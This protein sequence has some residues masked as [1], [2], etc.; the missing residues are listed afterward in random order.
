MVLRCRR[1]RLQDSEL[2]AAPD[3]HCNTACCSASGTRAPSDGRVHMRTLA[4]LG[5]IAVLMF[6]GLPTAPAQAPIVV[7]IGAAGTTSDAPI[8]I[9]DKKGYFREE[10]FEAK[11]TNF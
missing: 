6:A 10:G 4:A 7:T 8:Y 3:Q 1:G 11:V 2:G 5:P 9:A